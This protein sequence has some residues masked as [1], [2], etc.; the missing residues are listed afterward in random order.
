M[1]GSDNSKAIIQIHEVLEKSGINNNWTISDFNR[2][3]RVFESL[4]E[5]VAN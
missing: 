5:N 2:L 4:A 3:D 1:A